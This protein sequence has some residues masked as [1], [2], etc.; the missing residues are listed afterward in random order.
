[1][2]IRNILCA[3]LSVGLALGFSASARADADSEL[4]K[5]IVTSDRFN[6]LIDITRKM[7]KRI[8]ELESKL[9]IQSPAVSDPAGK[10]EIEQ[11]RSRVNQ[12]EA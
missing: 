8:D 6:K 3:A 10:A 1:M 12:L 2:Q 11:L 7:Y 9:A 4:A 5:K